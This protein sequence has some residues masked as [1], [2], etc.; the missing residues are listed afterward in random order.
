VID[1]NCTEC[2]GTGQYTGFNVV[3]ACSLCG[4]EEDTGYPEG[5]VPEILQ[6]GQYFDNGQFYH[7]MSDHLKFHG[8]YN[9][10]P[11]YEISCKSA[12]TLFKA[13]EFVVDAI[14]DDMQL[15]VRNFGRATTE[16]VLVIREPLTGGQAAD[17]TFFAWTE[18]GLGVR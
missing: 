15:L 18:I 2:K 10:I 7:V 3:E 13:E 17:G 14:R 16:R 6:P 1:P 4:V 12:K 8:W 9:L 5:F 11:T